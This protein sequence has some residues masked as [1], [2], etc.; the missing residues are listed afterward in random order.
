MFFDQGARLLSRFARAISLSV[1]GEQSGG[2][3]L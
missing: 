1:R 2:R 3:H